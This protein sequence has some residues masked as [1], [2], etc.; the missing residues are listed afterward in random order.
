REAQPTGQAGTGGGRPDE[1]RGGVLGRGGQGGAAA[2]ER[3]P[4]ARAVDDQGR[5]GAAA[6]GDGD[7]Q[8]G[9]A[10]DEG[11]ADAGQDAVDGGNHATG[12]VNDVQRTLAHA[13]GVGDRD[14]RTVK[15]DVGEERKPFGNQA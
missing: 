8:T 7:H 11:D 14:P 6:G 15:G 1:R 9:V 3:P 10:E 13:H 4:R 2:A 5:D 12:G